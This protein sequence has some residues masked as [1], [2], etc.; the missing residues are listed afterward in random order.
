MIVLE[1]LTSGVSSMRAHTTGVVN[2]S[3]LRGSIGNAKGTSMAKL[4]YEAMGCWQ[5]GRRSCA[6]EN[7]YLGI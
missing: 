3:Q 1:E 6:E 2:S 4:L 5:E 7:G